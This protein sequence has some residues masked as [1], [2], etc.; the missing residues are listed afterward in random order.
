MLKAIEGFNGR[1]TVDE[2]GNVYSMVA[3]GDGVQD[4]PVRQ[5]KAHDNTGYLRVALHRT[6]WD[7][8]LEGKY[9]HRLVA[10][11]FL[12]QPEGCTDV[13]HIDGNKH[14][15]C[16]SN[17]EWCT[18]Q[19]NIDHAWS[20]GLVTKEMLAKDSYMVYVATDKNGRTAEFDG[21]AELVKAGFTLSCVH[22]CIKKERKL[23]KGCT[24]SHYNKKE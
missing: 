4:T 6:K 14:N 11:T 15:N 19:Y 8:R 21:N 17:L 22:R 3:K 18:H 20:T 7:D 13:N 5:L 24:W 10:E 2:N 16:V 23:H 1:Y 9:V 12:E